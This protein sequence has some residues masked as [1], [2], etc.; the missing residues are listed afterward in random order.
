[1]ELLHAL[2]FQLCSQ[3]VQNSYTC[4]CRMSVLTSHLVSPP[5]PPVSSMW[6]PSFR[7][8]QVNSLTLYPWIH[9]F[10]NNKKSSDQTRPV[11]FPDVNPQSLPPKADFS[12]AAGDFVEI[13][14]QPGG[15]LKL[16]PENVP[17]R[18]RLQRTSVLS[19]TAKTARI[20][21]SAAVPKETEKME[22]LN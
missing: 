5:F 3:Q 20:F 15:V 22:T 16:R 19:C 12:M 11:R 7:C 18:G 9:Q 4:S 17:F 21:N 2:F 14:S 13:Y 10:S 1:M 8:D 6:P